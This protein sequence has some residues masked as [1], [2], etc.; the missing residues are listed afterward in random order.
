MGGT[1]S[2]SQLRV[3]SPTRPFF[4]VAIGSIDAKWTVAWQSAVSIPR[5]SYDPVRRRAS[6]MGPHRTEASI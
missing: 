5:G 2:P 3:N 1:I 4:I 6:W